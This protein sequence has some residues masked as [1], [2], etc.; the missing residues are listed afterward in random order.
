MATDE[1][2]GAVIDELNDA[3]ADVAD[4]MDRFTQEQ[5]AEIHEAV[6]SASEG[7]AAVIRE[8]MGE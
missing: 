8:E 6:A 2:V 7:A 3:I 4:D 5:S 1:E